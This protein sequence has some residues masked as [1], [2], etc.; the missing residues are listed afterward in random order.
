VIGAGAVVGRSVPAN[1]TVIGA[2]VDIQED[3][4]SS[5]VMPKWIAA[6]MV[7]ESGVRDDDRR[8]R[9]RL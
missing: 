6:R 4:P 3:R 1:S 8:P 2:K 7:G 5:G 9:G